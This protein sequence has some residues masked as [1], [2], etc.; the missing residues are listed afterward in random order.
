MRARSV[1]DARAALANMAAP[2]SNITLADRENIAIITAG[3]VPL[4]SAE[5][6]TL[7][8][9]PAQGWLEVNAWQGFI[10]FSENPY[11]ENP[12]SGVVVNTNNALPTDQFPRHFSFDWGD[13]QR[14]KRA[15]GLLNAR[16][17]H[18]QSS[19]ISI[20]TDTVSIS[21]RTLLP[22]MGQNL[23]LADQDATPG[24]HRAP[25]P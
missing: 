16:Q 7:G 5:N 1:P 23:W 15:T 24:T 12:E 9:I 18:T 13:T 14:I 21:A 6:E 17:F 20:Q 10:P 22:L 11:I 19:F 25:P 8:R 2:A 3:R 4:R